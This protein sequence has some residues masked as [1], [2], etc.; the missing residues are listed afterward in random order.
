MSSSQIDTA[1]VVA[2]SVAVTDESLSANLADGRVITVPLA[3]YPRLLHATPDERGRWELLADGRHVHWP[4]IDEDLSVDGLLL[5][6]PSAESDASLQ[7]WF[8]ARRERKPLT[9]EARREQ[10]T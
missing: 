7:E 6:R 3:W 4:D 5:G 10:S 1:E 8:A 2:T 9:L